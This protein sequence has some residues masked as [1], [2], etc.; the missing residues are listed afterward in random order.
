MLNSRTSQIQERSIVAQD[1]QQV[2]YHSKTYTS[3]KGQQG[4]NLHY[5]KASTLTERFNST[6]LEKWENSRN[7]VE[8]IGFN[9]EDADKILSKSFCWSY[10][11]FWGEDKGAT[12]PEPEA[13]VE[14]LG[15]LKDL[16]VDL[17]ELLTN[18]PEV[19]GLSKEELKANV[20]I[21]DASWGIT[22]NSL[23]N[24]IT[25]N[26]S[27]LG[28]NVDCKGDCIGQCTRCWVRF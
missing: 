15:Y 1:R 6:E 3:R 26:P 12:V 20:A 16:G 28:N 19:V 24:V 10:S 11:S 18:F 25:R 7:K 21:L 5:C 9:S 4:R 22:G 14:T 17:P 27:V 23:K 8:E 13:V 2:I